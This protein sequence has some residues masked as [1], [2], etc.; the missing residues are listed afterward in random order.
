MHRAAS[1]QHFDARTLRADFHV[2]G[3]LGGVAAARAAMNRDPVVLAQLRG[4][5]D[6]LAAGDPTPDRS[7]D[8]AAEI[9]RVQHEAGATPRLLAE[10]RGL[11]GFLEWA[12]RQS[13]RRGHS[14]LVDAHRRVIDAIAAGETSGPPR[15]GSR[16]P[17]PPPKR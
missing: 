14:D 1:V 17:G 13:D 8:L 9:V 11:G 2:L 7:H 16:M 4:L 3:L 12:A 6:E 15:P 10:L 5:L